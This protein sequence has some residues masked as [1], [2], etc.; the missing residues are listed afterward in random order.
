V[1]VWD[2]TTG[3]VHAVLTGHT[4][5]VHAVACT[6]FDG[7]PVAI[8]GSRDKTVRVWDLT[9]EAELTLLDYPGRALCVGPANEV[10]IGTGWGL[11]VI[12]RQPNRGSV[13]D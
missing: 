11:T 10:I 12:D 5:W 6:T 7:R 9:T 1:E 13:S 3:T 2:L 8:T 4:S